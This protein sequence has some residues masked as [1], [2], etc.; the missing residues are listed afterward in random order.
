MDTGNSVTRVESRTPAVERRVDEA[1]TPSQAVVTAIAE[2][3]DTDVR[4][5]PPLYETVDSDALDTIFGRRHD[6]TPRTDGRVEFDHHD[7]RVVVD[8]D[9]VRIFCD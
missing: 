9:R 6:G 4:E 2:A 3:L 1:N 7:C 8:P 5:L